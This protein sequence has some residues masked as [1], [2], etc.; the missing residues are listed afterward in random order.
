MT[1]AH[2][3]APD[4]SGEV[5]K[6][7]GDEARHAVRVLRVRP[8]EEITVSNGAGEVVRAVVTE[9]GATLSAD[10]EARRSEP[11]PRPALHVFA[12]IPKAGKLDLVVQKLTELGVEVIQPFP[13]S[14]SVA[15]WDPKKASAQTERLNAISREAA[16][17]SRRAWLAEVRLPQ[18]LET[19]ELPKAAFVLDEEAGLRLTAALPDEA[20]ETIALI[21]GPEGGF[22]REEVETL[23][24]RGV[25]PASL[26]P[27]ILRTETAA[28]VATTVAAVRYERMG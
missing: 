23:S 4:V 11:R 12:A 19:L 17:Q 21:V 10:V 26:G 1:A 6:L 28:L 15:R 24:A 9:A 20:P 8:G 18:R 27:L 16:K 25:T 7:E 14:R 2:F 22:E 5:V 13:A 3:F